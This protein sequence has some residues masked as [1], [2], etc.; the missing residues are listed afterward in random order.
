M[1]L[2][3]YRAVILALFSNLR[4]VLSIVFLVVVRL[5]VNRFVSAL[6]IARLYMSPFHPPFDA[7]ALLS[8]STN[9]MSMSFCLMPGSSPCISYDCALSLTS[10][11]ERR[12]GRD[13]KCPHC[14]NTDDSSASSKR[15]RLSK[16]VLRVDGNIEKHA[17]LGEVTINV[18]L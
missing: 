18:I 3:L 12:G 6:N 10:N 11:W 2:G 16:P 4:V 5:V 13:G 8:L 17:M 14:R 7:R 9:S 1:P 15:R